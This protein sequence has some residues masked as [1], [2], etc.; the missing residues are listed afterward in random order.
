MSTAELRTGKVNDVLRVLTDIVC[1]TAAKVCG[2]VP[3]KKKVKKKSDAK[4]EP[5]MLHKLKSLKREARRELRRT[6]R[7][8]GDALAAH[9]QFMRAVR[10]HHDLVQ[11]YSKNK[12]LKDDVRERKCFV[13]DPHAYAKR[14]LSPPV[15]GKPT[16]S[17]EV[18]DLYFKETYHDS[19]RS[20]AYVPMADFPRPPSPTHAFEVDFASFGEF[21]DICRSRSNGSAPGLNGIP[22]LL[23]KC[24]TE[25]RRYLWKILAR[26]WKDRMIPDTFQVGRIRLLPKSSDTSHPKLMR[27]ISVLNAEGRL[28]W[29]VFQKRLS[30]FM[31]TNGYID[32]RVQKGFMEG[33]AGC[34]EHTSMLWEVLTHA[35]RHQRT[36]AMSWLDLENAYGSVRHMLVQF[37]LKWYH[38]PQK[39]SELLFRYYDGIF[40]RVHTDDWVSNFFLLAIGVPQGCTASSVVFDVTFQVVLDMWKWITRD[41]H[42]ATALMMLKLRFRVPL[43]RMMCYSLRINPKTAKNLLMVF[44]PLS[45]GQ[46]H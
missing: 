29:T 24:C 41:V 20:F 34:V 45:N 22:Y 33:V 26:V 46:R 40:L 17:K 5:A 6:K 42:R 10:A 30:R 12:K 39:M 27:P 25:V 28:F 9:K 32:S 11:L 18:A 15:T 38:V 4:R 35:K 44:R 7:D 19:D 23:Y 31:L 8:G 14:L 1:N 37:A 16:F 2:T 13:Q 36:I 21:T 3:E 43:M